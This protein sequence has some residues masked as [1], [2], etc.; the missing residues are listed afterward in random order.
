MYS[1]TF[2]I[3]IVAIATQPVHQLQIYPIL[4]N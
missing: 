3:R 4:H 1:L 2:R